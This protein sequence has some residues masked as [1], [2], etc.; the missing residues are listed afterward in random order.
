MYVPHRYA[1]VPSLSPRFENDGNERPARAPL[2][3]DLINTMMDALGLFDTLVPLSSIATVS[4]VVGYTLPRREY[5]GL[6]FLMW[7]TL[8]VAVSL[9]D[10][11][12]Q[13]TTEWHK[14]SDLWGVTVLVGLPVVMLRILWTWFQRGSISGF[15]LKHVPLWSLL[16]LHIYRLD[17]LSIVAPF[18]R[19]TVPKV[20]GVQTI[21]LDV[22]MGATAV[23]LT[24]MLYRHRVG[25][26]SDRTATSTA[27][28]NGGLAALLFPNVR[29]KD[30]L[31]L[32]N[33][34]GM[35]D[36]C[37]AYVIFLF[38]FFGLGG[39]FIV[40]P[41]LSK[42][43][44]HPFPLLILFQVPLAVAIHMLLLTKLDDIIEWQSSDLPLHARRIRGNAL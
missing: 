24:V 30:A 21:V 18:W 17:G 35:Y 9:N 22:L 8:A 23:P 44:F 34:I 29:L 10:C 2:A 36:I 7:W 42:L 1:K 26:L 3:G 33:S 37:S 39:D 11:L 4:V 40:Q 31:W 32:W 16:A 41:P 43:G 6:F 14:Q 5:L 20:I 13:T 12:F 27:A 38:N 25:I 19:G 15:V 28:R